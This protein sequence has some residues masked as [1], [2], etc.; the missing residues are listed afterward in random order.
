MQLNRHPSK[1]P[2]LS[3]PYN[4]TVTFFF[5]IKKAQIFFRV[6]T[7]YNI[8]GSHMGSVHPQ[9]LH[10]TFPKSSLNITAE[11]SHFPQP[12]LF[13]SEAG[14]SSLPP[15]PL[16][17]PWPRRHHWLLC[18]TLHAGC[19]AM[20]PAQ[21]FP[22]GA[23]TCPCQQMFPYTTTKNHLRKSFSHKW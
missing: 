10:I 9:L 21:S 5:L 2:G 16:V 1:Q 19:A 14:H 18:L 13:S 3:G 23:Q 12:L 15:V 6:G 22:Q 20:T 8:L 11:W 4:C 17:I 7:H